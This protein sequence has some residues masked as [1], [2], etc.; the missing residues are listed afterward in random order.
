MPRRL[1]GARATDARPLD[2]DGTI[3][4]WSA[5][6][7]A[8]DAGTLPVHAHL[9][10]PCPRRRRHGFRGKS[11]AMPRSRSRS[12]S[13]S[14]KSS[15]VDMIPKSRLFKHRIRQKIRNPNHLRRTIIAEGR[16]GNVLSRQRQITKLHGR[17]SRKKVHHQMCPEDQGIGLMLMFLRTRG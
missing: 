8:G 15:L 6:P 3:A 12:R 1:L 13:A 14:D 17:G 4:R 9:R 16:N 10:T 2:T 5:A 7:N 11:I